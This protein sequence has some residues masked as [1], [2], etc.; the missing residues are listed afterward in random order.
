MQATVTLLQTALLPDFPSG[1]AIVYHQD[2]LYLVGD[3][4]TYVRVMDTQ[5]QEIARI[6]LFETTVPRIPKA[7]KA[8]LE[9]AVIREWEG[10]TTLLLIGSAAT[11]QREQLI[12]IPLSNAGT[13]LFYPNPLIPALQQAGLT[14]LNIEGATIIGDKLVWANRGNDT[15]RTNHLLVTVPDIETTAAPISLTMIAVDTGIKDTPLFTGISELCYVAQHDLLLLAVSVEAT[16][17]AYDDGEIGDSY[18][19][20]ITNVSTRLHHRALTCDGYVALGAVSEVLKQQKIE[21]ICVESITADSWILHLAS[22]NDAGATGL[23]RI[24]FRLT[25]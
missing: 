10:V 5:Y 20:W 19:A 14:E 13:P 6:P 2:K 16:A 15:H 11:P 4:A 23:F 24:S 25:S 22:D 3:D 17:N 9:A 18:I 1:S 7:Q 12:S 8:D 21:G